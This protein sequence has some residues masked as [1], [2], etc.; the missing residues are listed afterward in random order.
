MIFPLKN[1][2]RLTIKES[3]NDEWDQ[4]F[5]DYQERYSTWEEAEAG[6]K[7]A[8]EYITNSL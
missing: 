3:M 5:S 1:G 7:T 6:H 2:E 4:K 8:C